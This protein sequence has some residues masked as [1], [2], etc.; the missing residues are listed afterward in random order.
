[1]AVLPK[2]LPLG[3]V[4]LSMGGTAPMGGSAGHGDGGTSCCGQDPYP[5][6]WAGVSMAPA[7]WPRLGLQTASTSPGGRAA[8]V[9]PCLWVGVVDAPASGPVRTPRATHTHTHRYKEIIA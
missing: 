6:Q 9:F 5:G 2:P 1:M 4:S 7:P 3:A 8:S